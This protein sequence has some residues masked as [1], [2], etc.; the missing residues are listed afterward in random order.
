MIKEKIQTA[1]N[2]QINEE[3]ASGYLYLSMSVYFES[4]NLQGFSKWMKAQ[5]MEEVKHA[6][7]IYSYVVEKGG[8][9]ILSELEKPKS[10]WTSPLDAFES[11][12]AH[13]LK[14][15][16]LINALVDLSA[17]EKDHA[18]ANMLQWFVAE[19]VEEEASADEIVQKLRMIGDA[20]SA[21]FML[22]HE[23]GKREIK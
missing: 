21:I 16:G 15:T 14:I 1:L 7:K 4:A 20:K 23:L 9:V 6:M 17:A 5:A 10:E 18:T 11:A 12:Y 2:K 13:E 22:D 8:R 19:Q 3:L